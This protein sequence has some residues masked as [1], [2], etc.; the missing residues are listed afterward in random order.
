M[1]E[2]VTLTKEWYKT[3][4]VGYI[5]GATMRMLQWWDEQGIIMPCRNGNKR[6]YSQEN[7]RQI[8]RLKE[9]TKHGLQAGRAK[10]CLGW[11]YDRIISIDRPSVVNGVL[12][13][14]R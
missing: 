14:P 5:T 13:I 12:V 7:V 10:K 4:E 11:T 8:I 9:L 2:E 3:H 6:L 1:P